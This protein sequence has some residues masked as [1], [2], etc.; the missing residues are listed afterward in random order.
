MSE[1]ALKLI[2]ENRRTRATFLDL[3]KCGLSDVPAE[4]GELVWLEGLSLGDR[5]EEWNGEEWQ[6]KETR[7]R[8]AENNLGGLALGPLAGLT[9]LQT[10]NV[11][12]TKVADLGPLAGL[13]ALQTLNVSYTKVADLGPL[14][15]LTA[16]QRLN[17][18]Y[19]QV[20][21][22]GPL[23]GLTA[24]QTLDVSYTKV[25]DLG[26]LAG[27][28]ALRW[29][30]VSS[31]QIADL[32]PLAGL[33]ALRWLSVSGT[34]IADLEP[35]AALTALQRLNAPGT[36][37]ADLR[38]LAGLTALRKLYV[39]NTQIADLGPLAGLTALE[40]LSVLG[41]QIADLGPLAGLTALR[42]IDVSNTQIADL[43]PLA[44]LTALQRLD[45]SY[46]QIADLGSLAGLPVL[47][48]LDVSGTHVGDL[49]PLISLIRGGRPVCWSSR[50]WEG[51]GIYVQ[52]CPLR[53][54]PP[55]IVK[56]GNDAILNYFHER[57][58]GQID[59]LY[60]AK[61]LIVGEGGAG[62]TS[63]LR[64]L[65]Q[66]EQPLPGEDETTKGISIYRHEFQ[67]KNGRTFRLNVWDFGGQEIYHATH[68]FFLTHRSLYLL[69]DDTRKDYK[70]VSDPGFRNWL[71]LVEVFGGHSPVL[72][73]QNEK[74][75][76]SKAIDIGGIRGRYDNVKELYAGDLAKSDAAARL[77]DGIEFFAGTLS[78]IGEELPAAWVKIRG[79]VEA[80]AEETPYIPREEYF[81]I[82]KRHLD[83]DRTKA[84]HLSR[85]LHD[86]GV[87][88][89]FQ[90]DALLAHTV[91]LQNQWATEA[92]FRIL[93]DEVV[94]G[95]RGRF[96]KADCERLW[97]DSVYADMH[98]ELLALME[99]FELC[100]LLRDSHPRAWLAPQL[101]P[102]AKPEGLTG[103]GAAGDLTLRYRYEFL[104]HGMISR[105]TVRMHRF[106]REPEMAWVTGVLFERDHTAV[107]V[108]L[109]ANGSEIEL[110]ARGPEAKALLSVVAGDL[111]ALNESFEGLRGRFDKWVPC[112][113]KRCATAL[114]AGF[115]GYRALLQRKEDNRLLVEC[116]GGSYEMVSVLE[117]LEGVRVDRLPGWAKEDATDVRTIRVFLASSSELREDRDA[118]EL[119][120]LQENEFSSKRGI[121]LKID[122]WETILSAMS[123]TRSQDEYNLA[124]RECDVF[125]CLSFTKAGKFTSEE[126]EVAYRQFK[127]RGAPRIFTYF[128]DAEIRIGDLSEEDFSSLHRFQKRIKELGHFWS[129]YKNTD[130]LKLDFGGQLKK[131]F[132]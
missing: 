93:D 87:I 12:Y 61:M 99:R 7:N 84:L 31:T 28:T 8:G 55:E 22:L 57:E 102:P 45:V 39:A 121:R 94:K 33:T 73:F 103:W 118:F 127:E 123:A 79:D 132:E 129:V 130:H 4:V 26:P 10:L 35:L 38:P 124:V 51:K 89:H 69:V 115:L 76:R 122:R 77:R 91:I 50:S 56:Q 92:V 81:Q 72:I 11:S 37:I 23:A 2:A 29:L 14:A 63:L 6:V 36:Q 65:Y 75:G 110:R 106:V 66:P 104:P 62:K 105:L 21:D 48:T 112:N 40:K 86:L 47:Q 108:E 90:D 32:G 42:W 27:M 1:L 52:H 97:R 46:S 16:L 80:R 88:L 13:T 111:D 126:F 113:C 71:E 83:F 54:P 59:H 44:G 15:G 117:L 82:Y 25:A 101:L 49:F 85:Y 107:L 95:Q 96:T 5:W 24:L 68:Q 18:S 74:G 67:M 17:V 125:V 20:A 19:T 78:H 53:N 58:L 114:V 116:P 131:L 9:A 109:L 34:Q 70:S 119:Y 100:Y 30:D 41:T 60:E 64:R 120:F 3:G 128:K 98:P 43:G